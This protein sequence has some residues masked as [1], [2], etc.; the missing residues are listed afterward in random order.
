MIQSVG[1][2]G[3]IGC[4]VHLINSKVCNADR[5]RHGL[6]PIISVKG[7]EPWTDRNSSGPAMSLGI[8]LRIKGALYDIGFS[9]WPDPFNILEPS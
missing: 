8:E 4:N 7:D 2:W 5:M 3:F 9:D 1:V 6:K